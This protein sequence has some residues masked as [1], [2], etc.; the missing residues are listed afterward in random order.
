M[1]TLPPI[2]FDHFRRPRN[3]GRLEPP[4]A[5]GKVE[6]RREGSTVSVY[7]QVRDERVCA[8]R[9]ELDGD[10]TPIA[11]LSLL[12]TWAQ[13]RPVEELERSSPEAV[14]SSFALGP[15]FLPLLVIPHE[16]LSAALAELKGRPVPPGLEGPVVC[17]CLH[18]RQGRLL[19]AIRERRLTTVEEVQHWTRACTGCR[20]CRTDVE[21]LL[22]RVRREGSRAR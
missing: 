9:F 16:A 1:G 21:A 12:T 11:G 2:V 8:A 20:S 15:E 18:V 10:R 7:L 22:E 6:G 3:Q 17:H 19:R 5:V 13:G 4:A 14:A